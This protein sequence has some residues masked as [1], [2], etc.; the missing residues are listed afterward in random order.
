MK[1]RYMGIERWSNV[2][3]GGIQ[4][5][6]VLGAGLPVYLFMATAAGLNILWVVPNMVPWT[7]PKNPFWL[8]SS[9]PP[10]NPPKK[11]P[12]HTHFALN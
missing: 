7:L 10:F 9:N 11:T 6:V 12:T 3:G 1:V 5:I 8:Q 2:H 4:E